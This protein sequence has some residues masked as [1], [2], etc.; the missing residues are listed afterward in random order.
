MERFH[1]TWPEHMLSSFAAFLHQRAS[2]DPADKTWV[3]PTCGTILPREIKPGLYLRRTCACEVRLR[4][5]R[6]VEM[7]RRQVQADQRAQTFGWIG[8]EWAEQRLEQLTFAT[9]DRQRQAQAFDQ[10][11]AFAQA[12]KGTLALT[13]SY[14]SGKT[15]LLVAI[16]N[17]RREAN[18]PCLYVSAVALFE[19]IQDR[20]HREQDHQPLLQRAARTPLLLIDDLDKPKPSEFRESVYYSLFNQ[21]NLAGLPLAIT[22]NCHPRELERWIGGAALSR[23]MQGLIPLGMNGPD[24]RMLTNH[25]HR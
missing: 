15:H 23:L 11:Q 13:G 3:C 24:Y 4:E 19:T 7:L 20:I 1:I 12:P 25:M 14:G 2:S 22:C 16:A 18:L 21:R 17:A 10:A 8:Q 5:A 6:E 9:F